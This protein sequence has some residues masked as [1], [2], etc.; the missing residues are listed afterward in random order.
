MVQWV[1]LSLVGLPVGVMA[2]A[3]SARANPVEPL[4]EQ[5]AIAQP[6]PELN[7]PATTGAEWEAQI[8]QSLVQVTGVELNPTQAG[9]NL[10]LTAATEL[11]SADSNERIALEKLAAVVGRSP[12]ELLKLL[13]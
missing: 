12:Q 3:T 8:A 1:C 2:W 7:A 13:Q 4:V 11:L 10:V 6:P 9:L 5:N